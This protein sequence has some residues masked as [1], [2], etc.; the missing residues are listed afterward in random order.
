MNFSGNI[1]YTPSASSNVLFHGRGRRA[2]VHTIEIGISL[3]VDIEL[4]QT[5][6]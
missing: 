1:E 6:T 2:G 3:D 4:A 5:L